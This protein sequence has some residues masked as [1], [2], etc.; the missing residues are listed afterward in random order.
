MRLP[1]LARGFSNSRA[2]TGGAKAKQAE[3]KGGQEA[4]RRNLFAK[5]RPEESKSKNA[6]HRAEAV[7]AAE[8]LS[9]FLV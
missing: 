8:E 6:V 3:A 2:G 5:I 4:A 7:C 1:P 9:R